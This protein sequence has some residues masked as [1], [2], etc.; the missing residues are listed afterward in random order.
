MYIMIKYR[1]GMAGCTSDRLMAEK[2]AVLVDAAWKRPMTT[3]FLT[4]NWAI[5]S[6]P[7]Y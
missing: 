2:P 3:R 5:G 1:T 7:S 6:E 4:L